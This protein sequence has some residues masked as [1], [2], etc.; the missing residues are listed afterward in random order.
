LIWASTLPRAA[1]EAGTQQRIHDH[2]AFAQQ[3]RRERPQLA[4]TALEVFARLTRVIAQ[5]IRRQ[6]VENRDRQPGCLCETGQNI[7][8]TAVVSSS[9]HNDDAMS[10]RP[11]C[12]QVA[13]SGLSGTF[14]QRV[15]RNALYVDG[16]SIERTNL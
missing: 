16:M 9:A 2:L 5:L 11:A 12:T 10:H 1:F 4:A 8:I 13:E 7:P 3:V 14:H 6:G 15:T